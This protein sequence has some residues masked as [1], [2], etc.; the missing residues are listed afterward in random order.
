MPQT[1]EYVKLIGLLAF[2]SGIIKLVIGFLR[3]SYGAHL[4][5]SFIILGIGVLFYS[6]G[7][8]SQKLTEA[9]EE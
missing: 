7:L 3:Y 4:L 2:L 1:F 6:I 9:K 5:S 8:I